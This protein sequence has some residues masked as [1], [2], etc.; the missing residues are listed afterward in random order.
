MAMVLSSHFRH[1]YLAQPC[2]L[3][4]SGCEQRQG[5]V[6][7]SSET[8]LELADGSQYSTGYHERIWALAMR[9]SKRATSSFW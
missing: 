7:L 2:C 3:V 4:I 6:L 8:Q 1:C 9:F 5:A